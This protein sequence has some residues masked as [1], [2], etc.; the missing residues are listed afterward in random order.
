[1]LRHLDSYS[2][3]AS[4]TTVTP[5]RVG[6]NA[7][8]A[9]DGLLDFKKLESLKKRI[10][11]EL[12]KFKYT[13]KKT[14]AGMLISGVTAKN[15]KQIRDVLSEVK[16]LVTKNAKTGGF[17]V[18][19]PT[20]ANVKE[21]VDQLGQFKPQPTSVLALGL[22]AKFEP[23]NGTKHRK[24]NQFTYLARRCAAVKERSRVTDKMQ[25]LAMFFPKGVLSSALDKELNVVQRAFTSHTKSSVKVKERI[26]AARGVIKE[27]KGE[28]LDEAVAEMQTLLTSAG[29]K[30][31]SV[32]IGTSVMGQKTA[33]IRLPKSKQVVTLG[34]SDMGAFN[35]AKK[36]SS[37]SSSLDSLS[38]KP[39]MGKT[40]KGRVSGD[41]V[42]VVDFKKKLAQS[43]MQ[44]FVE[45]RVKGKKG[46]E[47]ISFN[48]F[49]S[50]FN[51]HG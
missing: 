28:A 1:M 6:T 19:V 10:E 43:G 9:N 35:K 13:A 8:L 46:T 25:V 22:K 41:I 14:R 44:K 26:Q 42:E 37:Q 11:K 49:V 27:Q 18:V 17:D 21:V 33:Y 39:V 48:T 40:Y 12:A 20:T 24:G 34:L 50:Q 31:G 5:K 15:A 47:L 16:P 2:A 36:L 51:L 4:A 38:A 23:F 3:K 32:V 45:V 29:I 7:Y 30:E